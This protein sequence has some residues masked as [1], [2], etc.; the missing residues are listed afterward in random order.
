MLFKMVVVLVGIAAGSSAQAAC[1]LE[2]KVHVLQ[3]G[4]P[5]ASNDFMDDNVYHPPTPSTS[6]APTRTQQKDLKAVFGIAAQRSSTFFE[7]LCKLDYIFI[8]KNSGPDAPI[9]WGFWQGSY[10]VDQISTGKK[11]QAIGISEALWSGR[12]FPDLQTIENCIVAELLPGLP[13]FT[14][15]SSDHS[16]AMAL[17]GVLAHEMGI[18]ATVRA[19][20]FQRTAS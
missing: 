6:D 9:G 7:A 17:L 15:T 13:N 16:S 18:S 1:D 14:Y 5:G 10:Q 3:P 8:D 19:T 12:S 11:I 20:K 4:G 2:S